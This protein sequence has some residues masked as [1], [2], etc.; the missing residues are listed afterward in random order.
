[1]L[2]ECLQRYAVA[3]FD[4]PH[5]ASRAKKALD[6]IENAMKPD[7]SKQRGGQGAQVKL[8]RSEFAAIKSV[9]SQFSKILFIS[10]LP[11]VRLPM[12]PTQHHEIG[13]PLP[14]QNAAIDLV[15]HPW[16]KAHV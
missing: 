13:I 2:M 5:S 3:E 9:Q 15:F 12:H 10:N 16:V 6:D 11:P 4:I 8:L 1:M 7:A 14:C